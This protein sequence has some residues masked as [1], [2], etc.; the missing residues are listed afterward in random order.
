MRGIALFSRGKLVNEYSFYDEKATSHGYSYLTGQLDVSF[1]DKWEKDVISTN[2]RSL[3]WEDDDT[4]KLRDYLSQAISHVYKGQR[5]L[6]QE[7]KKKKVEGKIGLHID[8]W[9]DSLPKHDGKLARKMVNAIID[10]EEIETDKAGELL[11]FVKDSFQFESFKEF[12]AEI[13][14]IQQTDTENIIKLLKDWQLIEAREFYKLSIGRIE[15]INKFEKY[16]KQKVKEVPTMHNFL[17]TF[18][19]LLDPRIIE[20]KDEVYYS[21]LLKEK[22]PDSDEK[23]ESD[24]RIDFLCVGL[25]SNFFIIELKKPA[26]KIR[27]KDIDQASDYRT[28]IENHFGNDP[29]GVKQ[30]VAYVVCGE[31][32]DERI[33]KEHVE[34]YEKAGKIYVKTYGELLVSAKNYH[35]E[36][37]EKYDQIQGT[38]PKS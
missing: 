32:S 20:F 16:I 4:I 37:I 25:A 18:P 19:W 26:H 7:S 31:R 24:R 13:E 28:F 27:K 15:T 10:S 22:Y 35:R 8:E 1:I 34:T 14:E 3:N 6:K 5:K 29:Q 30:I 11:N 33:T 17:K 21:Q 23:M 9:I 36:F 38:T 2:R 12:A